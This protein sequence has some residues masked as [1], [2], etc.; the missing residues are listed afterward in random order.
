MTD[1]A[2]GR[3]DALKE[4]AELVRSMPVT[5]NGMSDIGM[6]AVRSHI[7]QSIEALAQQPELTPI[8]DL[9]R[10]ME[11][12]G[13]GEELQKSRDAAAKRKALAQQPEPKREC[14]TCK[15]FMPYWCSLDPIGDV[16]NPKCRNFDHWQPKGGA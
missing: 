6:L 10:E 7:S 16:I 3:A 14:G 5:A 15:Y 4:A 12:E 2:R 9:V 13:L 8:S 1:Y 11:A